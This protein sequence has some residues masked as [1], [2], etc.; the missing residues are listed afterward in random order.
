MRDEFN[1]QLTNLNNDLTEMGAL[2]ESA[3]SNASKAFTEK[4]RLFALSAISYEKQIDQKERDIEQLCLTLLLKQQPIARDLRLISSALKMI[5]DMERIGDQA[6]DIAE[7][8]MTMPQMHGGTPIPEH[9]SKM[10]MATINMVNNSINAFVKNDTAIAEEVI[11]GDDEVDELFDLVRT[12]LIKFISQNPDNAEFS[13]DIL[14]VAKY[15]ER[16][17]DH[18]TNIAEWV[19]FS[20]NGKHFNK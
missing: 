18:A 15:F 9:I 13:V 1:K 12:D 11:K 19:Y 7:I 6:A 4:N 16:I 14:M 20:I 17:G 2:I 5:T 8:A 3:I 10:A